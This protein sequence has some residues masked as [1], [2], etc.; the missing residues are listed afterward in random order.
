MKYTLPSIKMHTFYMSNLMNF[1]DCIQS[2]NYHL[3]KIENTSLTPESFLT[4]L[5]S[6]HPIPTWAIT[7]LIVV[8]IDDISVLDLHVNGIVQYLLLHLVSCAQP[9]S[10]FHPYYVYMSC[11][12]WV[13]CSIGWTYHSVFIHSLVDEY[14][15]FFQF[16]G[17]TNKFALHIHGAC[18]QM[19]GDGIAGS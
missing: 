18:G 8:T 17:T 11:S 19:S 3:A 6:W 2:R 15:G 12:F 9:L 14:L 5:S 1:R 13:L 10:E 16:G 4:S 7:N